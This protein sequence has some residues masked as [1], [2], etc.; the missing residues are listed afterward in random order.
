MCIELRTIAGNT[1]GKV[2]L[3]LPESFNVEFSARYGTVF[4]FDMMPI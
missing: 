4:A 3:Y 2:N 1:A